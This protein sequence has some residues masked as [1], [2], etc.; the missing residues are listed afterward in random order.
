[1]LCKCGCGEEII[2]KR[3]HKWFPPKY[4]RGHYA[5]L[6]NIKGFAAK[7]ENHWAWKGGVRYHGLGYRYRWN[8][9]HPFATKEGYILEHRLVWETHNKATLLSWTDIHHKN[10]NILD[11]RI[12]NLEPM[13]HGDHSRYHR[14]TTKRNTCKSL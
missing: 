1:M 2:Y 14:V 10:E 5:K 7:G 4:K 13:F 9:R 12:E 6:P 8:P 11:N 3:H